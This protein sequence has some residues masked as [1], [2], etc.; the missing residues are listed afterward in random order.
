M[1]VNLSQENAVPFS[2]MLLDISGSC[3]VS[4]IFKGEQKVKEVTTG[5]NVDL[6]KEWKNLLK[7]SLTLSQDSSVTLE[8]TLTSGTTS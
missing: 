5:T 2:M 1:Y 6:R 7:N 3:L 8:R 4:L